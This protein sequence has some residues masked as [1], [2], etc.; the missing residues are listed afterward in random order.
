[1]GFVL[2]GE[3]VVDPTELLNELARLLTDLGGSITTAAVRG[4]RTER[5]AVTGVTPHDGSH[6]PTDQ[7]V[8]AAGSRAPSLL[9]PTGLRLPVTSGKG[10]SFT[11]DSPVVPTRTLYLLDAKAGVS[12]LGSG[13]RVAGTMEFSGLDDSLDPRRLGA[14]VRTATPFLRCAS[15][16]R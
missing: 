16:R 5:G 1:A 11:A 10:Y 15:D 8:V 12:T 6:R 14:L 4:V 13:V 9:K 2:P 3:G 7:V